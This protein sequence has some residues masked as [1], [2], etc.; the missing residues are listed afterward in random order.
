M[1]RKIEEFM[2]EH[3][4]PTRKK[5]IKALG[6]ISF[7]GEDALLMYT[8]ACAILKKVPECGDIDFIVDDKVVS[9]AHRVNEQMV[10]LKKVHDI[11][12]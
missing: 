9:Y 12:S 11:A 4:K 8:R 2:K 7:E 1:N 6:I 10:T 3:T 5:K